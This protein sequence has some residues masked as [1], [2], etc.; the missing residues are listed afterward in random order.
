MVLRRSVL[1]PFHFQ[2]AKCK[3][4]GPFAN[5]MILRLTGSLRAK[6]EWAV[7]PPIPR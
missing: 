1:P 6:D 7:T 4:V 2:S 3:I 5:M